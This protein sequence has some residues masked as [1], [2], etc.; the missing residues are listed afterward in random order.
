MALTENALEYFEGLNRG[1]R[2]NHMRQSKSYERRIMAIYDK[3]FKDNYKDLDK[4][5][6]SRT[7]RERRIVQTAYTK[8]LAQE[9]QKLANDTGATLDK[10]TLDSFNNMN[11]AIYKHYTSSDLYKVVND[12]VNVVNKK[13]LDIMTKGSIYRDGQ[14]LSTRIWKASNLS[15]DKIETAIGSCLAR[16]ISSAEAGNIIA[17]FGAGGHRTWDYSKI[18]EKLGDGYARKYGAGGID[19]EGLR[20]MRTTRTHLNQ[21]AVMNEKYVNPYVGKIRWHSVHSAGRT[22]EECEDRDGQIYDVNKCPFDHPNGLCWNEPIYCDV[23]GKVMTPTE[24]AE[25]MGKWMRGEGN[26]GTMDVLYG[27]V[28]VGK[29]IPKAPVVPKA[30]VDPSKAEREEF[31]NKYRDSI[32]THY[33]K[34]EQKKWDTYLDTIEKRL[35]DAP[36]YIQKA[37]YS[38]GEHLVRAFDLNNAGA[39]YSPGFKSVSMDLAECYRRKRVYDIDI[40]TTFFHENGHMV[41][42]LLY[43]GKQL[44]SNDPRFLKAL[45]KDYKMQRTEL[46]RRYLKETETPEEYERRGYDK[47]NLTELTRVIP[48]DQ[49]PNLYYYYWNNKRNTGKDFYHANETH[50]MQDIVEGLSN[51]KVR[52]GWGHGK[53]YWNRGN[54]DEEVCSE[55]WA[56]MFERYTDKAKKECVEKYFPNTTKEFENILKE[57]LKNKGVI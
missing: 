56:H 47:M 53:A 16:G 7:S 23:S 9:L 4:L 50:G 34:T 45:K 38:A 46:R 36:E 24:M 27:N 35:K 28:K 31:L 10:D 17:E 32:A 30:P 51:A 25:D 20:L 52:I 39:Y 22:C 44:L 55:A 42:D 54:R 33:S 18:K 41:D 19:Y 3:A 40:A 2:A 43:N 37:Y 49:L 15:G 14:G 21:L 26:T 29:H 57:H 48:N 13:I 12:N 6:H 1:R 11:R 8:Q 5:F